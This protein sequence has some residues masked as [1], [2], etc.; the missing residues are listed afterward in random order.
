MK[1]NIGRAAARHNAP[2]QP[3][4]IRVGPNE[5]GEQIWASIPGVYLNFS[6]NSG[7]L[8]RDGGTLH[9]GGLSLIKSGLSLIKSGLS[10]LNQVYL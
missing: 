1:H 6:L 7:G 3:R 9:T 10:L 8:S 5:G 2:K 4:A